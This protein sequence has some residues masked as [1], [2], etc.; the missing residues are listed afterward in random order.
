MRTPLLILT[1]ATLYLTAGVD[2]G[3]AQGAAAPAR[4]T[5]RRLI[6]KRWVPLWRA[7]GDDNDTTIASAREHLATREAVYVLDA[8]GLQLHAFHADGGRLWSVGSKGRGPG[9]LLRPVDLNLSPS[10]EIGVLDPDNGRVSVFSIRGKL[11]RTITN[12]WMSSARSLCFTRRGTLL[13]HVVSTSTSVVEID[14]AGRE[15]RQWP[16]PWPVADGDN[17]FLTSMSFRRGEDH[18]DCA[19]VTTFGFGLAFVRESGQI[20]TFPFVEHLAQPT[21][22]RR[23]LANGAVGTYLESGENATWQSYVSGD[24]TFVR[25]GGKHSGQLVDLYD[26]SGRYL[27]TW[28]APNEDRIVYSHGRMYGLTDGTATPRLIAFVAAS[29]SSRVL[30]ELRRRYPARYRRSSA[31]PTARAATQSGKPNPPARTPAR[32]PPPA[33]PPPPAFR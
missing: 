5:E 13:L 20:D 25:V 16:F 2:T 19:L 6:S 8:G 31:I 24:T 14:S 22:V 7:G 9:E 21:F 29:D 30:T 3:M 23:K 18:R 17:T 15:L 12:P 27:E 10:G 26:R 28:S 33:A 1:T 4:P 11:T 32:R